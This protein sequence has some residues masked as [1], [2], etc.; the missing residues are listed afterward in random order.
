MIEIFVYFHASVGSKKKLT[1][2]ALSTVKRRTHTQTF[3]KKKGFYEYWYDWG[4]NVH[5]VNLYTKKDTFIDLDW[6]SVLHL[7][8][9]KYLNARKIKRY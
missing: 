1:D 9:Y 7:Y 3:K 6:L 2:L 4:H 5:L 8:N